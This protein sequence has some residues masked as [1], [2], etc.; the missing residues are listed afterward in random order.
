MSL[1]IP[2]H[3][4][5]QALSRAFARGQHAVALTCLTG[6]LLVVLVFQWSDPDV[7]RVPAAPALLPLLFLRWL[8]DRTRMGFS[9]AR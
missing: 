9:S 7:V 8:K 1:G 6:S 3:L 5:P 2:A 4:A